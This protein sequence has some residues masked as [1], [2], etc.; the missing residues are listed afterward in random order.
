[1][2][3][4][5]AQNLREKIQNHT[6]DCVVLMYQMNASSLICFFITKTQVIMTLTF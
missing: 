4:L 6:H 5:K 2:P 1:M 3:S